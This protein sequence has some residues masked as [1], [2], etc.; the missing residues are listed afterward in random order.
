MK[1]NLLWKTDFQ[2]DVCGWN[3]G[4]SVIQVFWCHFSEYMA[5]LDNQLWVS[6]LIH[7]I[8]LVLCAVISQ[9]MEF[10]SYV[11]IFHHSILLILNLYFSNCYD[12]GRG[13]SAWCIFKSVGVSV[14]KWYGPTRLGPK[15]FVLCPTPSPDGETGVKDS[16]NDLQIEKICSPGWIGIKQLLLPTENANHLCILSKTV[17]LYLSPLSWILCFAPAKSLGIG[18]TISCFMLGFV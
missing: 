17:F 3:P 10:L 4:Q 15:P 6:V 14:A 7:S 5:K 8:P 18:N 13:F 2:S 16:D 1:H 9:R 11:F 12:A